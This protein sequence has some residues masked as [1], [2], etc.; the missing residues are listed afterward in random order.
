MIKALLKLLVAV[1]FIWALADPFLSSTNSDK[2]DQPLQQ[3]KQPEQ[4]KP[5]HNVKLPDFS[6]Y[7]DVKEKKR[8]FFNFIKPH[9]KAENKKI[10]TQR[11]QLDIA[12][13]M[14]D[15][16]QPLTKKQHRNLTKI[17]T[18]YG[19]PQ[20]ISSYNL[21]LALNYV[22]IIPKELVLIQ[23]AKE[24]AWGTSRFARI[25]LNFF[26]QW[27]YSKGCGM[28]P[29]RRNAGDVHEV[30]AFK[31]VSAAVH[32]YFKNI[33]THD[34]YKALRAI[35]ADLR[36]QQAPI[37]AIKLTQGLKSYSERGEPYINEL[38][39]MINQNRVYFND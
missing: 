20:T 5:L 16:E 7:K 23:A 1:F 29:K 2:T 28:I 25:G 17:L 36:L 31:S 18:Q 8:A 24:S 11:A 35:R 10:L 9:V 27:C 33:N 13:L 32:A 15:H 21:A 38:N 30:A 3:K 22:D 14:L 12:K 6:S 34:A 19:L 4:E 39:K 37:D 26:G